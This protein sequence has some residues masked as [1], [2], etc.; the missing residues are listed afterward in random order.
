MEAITGKILHKTFL[1][2]TLLLSNFLQTGLKRSH[3]ELE[4][5]VAALEAAAAARDA[6]LEQLTQAIG[7][8][9]RADQVKSDRLY[10]AMVQAGLIN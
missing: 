7:T 9:F 4:G 3:T 5:R 1:C 2:Y 10:A 6:S 8:R